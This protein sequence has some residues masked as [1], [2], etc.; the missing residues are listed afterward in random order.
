MSVEKARLWTPARRNDYKNFRTRLDGHLEANGLSRTD[1]I[2]LL[3]TRFP[4]R[5]SGHIDR[6]LLDIE[7]IK[8]WFNNGDWDPVVLYVLC[9]TVEYSLLEAALAICAL[10][11]DPAVWLGERIRAGTV[12]SVERYLDGK[13]SFSTTKT[14]MSTKRITIRSGR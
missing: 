7:T 9:E 1:A 13:R 11:Q 6:E 4:E 8:R 5:H 14:S 10:P 12:L 2:K 3:L